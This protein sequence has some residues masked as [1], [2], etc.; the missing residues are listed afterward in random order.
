M[1]AKK[2]SRIGVV[3]ADHALRGAQ[4]I[5]GR[6]VTAAVPLEGDF[7]KSL[8]QLLTSS[9]FVGKDVSIGIE[10]KN[11]LVESLVVPPGATKS[12]RA[13]C[14]ERLKGDPVFNEENAALGVAVASSPTGTGP[15]MVIHAAVLH[16]RIS[17]VMTAC[18]ELQL[19]VHAVEAAAL[20]AW[21]AWTG[22]GMQ[23][24]L[25][26]T[27]TADVVQAGIDGRLLFCRIVERPISHVE[28][29]A[30]IS[31]AASLLSTDSFSVLTCSGVQDTDLQS[32]AQ[33]LG[34]VVSAPAEL[35]EDASATGLG[36]DGTILTEF[37]PDAERVIRKKR[38]IRR[39]RA[40]MSAAAGALVLTAGLLGY[41]RIDNLQTQNTLIQDRVDSQQAGE[42][43]LAAMQ[44]ELIKE[45]TN[46][47]HMAGVR[48]GHKMS[49][50]F[51]IIANSAPEN[52]LLEIITIDDM[53]SADK[54]SRQLVAA[55]NG[56]AGGDGE[57]RVFADALLATGAFSDVRIEAS[58]R[59]IL[60]NGAGG[61]RFRIHAT[62][63]TR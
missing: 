34:M 40:Y 2:A 24:R 58:Q 15:S 37:T 3:V 28:L 33:D 12:A 9:P 18:R 38:R 47:A 4:R 50:L 16:E 10:G 25:V 14:A 7:R 27:D 31:R 60:A 48:P 44:A 17:K 61:E 29:R 21:R 36:T 59:V 62:A 13:V 42:L 6:L 46:S 57:V 11:V 30:T 8:K 26:R 1:K 52:L 41:Q 54:G 5:E 63:E 43:Q 20:A 55:L 35:V 53:R 22:D 23:V 32:M 39:V 49:L 45:Q 19:Q 56:L 51:G